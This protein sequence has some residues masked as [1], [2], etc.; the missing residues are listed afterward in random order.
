[1]KAPACQ[2]DVDITWLVKQLSCVDTSVVPQFSVNRDHA[3]C[4]TPRRNPDVCA[5]VLKAYAAQDS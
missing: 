3:K 5:A 2:V 1:V 4:A